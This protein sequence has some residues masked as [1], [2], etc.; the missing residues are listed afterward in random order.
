MWSSSLPWYPV[1]LI[2]KQLP[3]HPL[4][5]HHQPTFL[6]QYERPSF[7]PIQNDRQNY[8]SVYFNLYIFG[9]Q[10]GRQMIL[11]RMIAIIPLLQSALNFFINA[12]LI[13]QGCSQT[14]AVFHPFEGIIFCPCV[15]IFSCFL[16]MRCDHIFSFI[17]IYSQTYLLTN[18]CTRL[19]TGRSQVRFPMVSLEFSVT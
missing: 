11:H 2:S 18:N 12:I 17:S 5:E 16:F 8:I 7:T 14:L 13:C 10:T 15:V 19:Q 6:P 4:L 3:Q 1:H 9:Q